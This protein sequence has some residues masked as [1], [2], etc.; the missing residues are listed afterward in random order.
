MYMERLEVGKGAAVDGLS[1]AWFRVTA[2]VAAVDTALGKW[3]TDTHGIG[4]ADYRAVL[5]LSRASDREL[6]LN[7]LARRVGLNQSSV[8]RLVERLE[9]KGLAFRDTCPEDGRG[10]YAVITDQGMDTV[11]AVREPYEAKIRELL[12][13]VTEEHPHLDRGDAA[14]ALEVVAALMR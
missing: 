13:H 10:V 2:L 9:G 3:L 8:T 12:Q 5:H 11:E 14:R 7:D 4:L 1:T 6:R